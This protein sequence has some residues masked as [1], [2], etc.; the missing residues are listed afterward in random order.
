VWVA[1]L[2]RVADPPPVVADLR[3]HRLIDIIAILSGPFLGG[4]IPLL[5]SQSLTFINLIGS[6]IYA[7][8][9]CQAASALTLYCFDLQAPPA[10]RYVKS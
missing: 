7:I 9:V 2:E 10:A 1:L 4:L 6:I 8:I 3:L 5:T